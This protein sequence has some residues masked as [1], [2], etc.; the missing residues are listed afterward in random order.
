MLDATD[1]IEDALGNK[2]PSPYFSGTDRFDQEIIDPRLDGL[3]VIGV[4]RA[5]PGDHDKIDVVFQFA[6]AQIAA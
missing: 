1:E 3:V 4:F 5:P 2:E 6:S